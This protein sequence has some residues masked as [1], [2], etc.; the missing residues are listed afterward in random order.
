MWLGAARAVPR[1]AQ[2]HG[3]TSALARALSTS[4]VE[5]TFATGELGAK[6]TGPSRMWHV[7]DEILSIPEAQGD[8]VWNAPAS[9]RFSHYNRS[10]MNQSKGF[11]GGFALGPWGC[12]WVQLRSETPGNVIDKG[13]FFAGGDVE[14]FPAKRISKHDGCKK[15]H[16][17]RQPQGP[18]VP[19]KQLSVLNMF[20]F[21]WLDDARP[22]N[23]HVSICFISSEES[24]G[25]LLDMNSQC[26]AF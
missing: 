10:L 15:K 1:E 23:F 16:H 12:G 25:E 3:T 14:I 18:M 26:S 11:V 20:L 22:I 19:K 9:Q 7:T 5:H 13:Y 4:G 24:I 8:D 17:K 6:P 21:R 2:P